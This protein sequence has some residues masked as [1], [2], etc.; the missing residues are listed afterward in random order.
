MS[1]QALELI[2]HDGHGY[3]WSI[4]SSV[5]IYMESLTYPTMKGAIWALYNGNIKWKTKQATAA[6]TDE[7][8]M[9]KAKVAA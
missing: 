7:M 2:V 6:L 4:D 5:G 1:E 8:V 3:Y 9:A